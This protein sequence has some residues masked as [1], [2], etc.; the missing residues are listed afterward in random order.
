[1]VPCSTTHFSSPFFFQ[2]VKSFSLKR[3]T[4]PLS[5]GALATTATPRN[6]AAA[7]KAPILLTVKPPSC[8]LKNLR[9]WS[10]ET[11]HRFSGDPAWFLQLPRFSERTVCNQCARSLPPPPGR[12]CTASSG[13]R[14]R[15]GRSASLGDHRP[16]PHI[17]LTPYLPHRRS[18]KSPRGFPS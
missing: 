8:L 12:G 16:Q 9:V 5:G 15:T 7:R 14:R 6:I 4:H 2:P 18:K 1:M 10:E 3:D 17:P 13:R 11:Y